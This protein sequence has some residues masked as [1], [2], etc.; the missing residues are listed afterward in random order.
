M[1]AGVEWEEGTGGAEQ[2][3]KRSGSTRTEPEALLVPE[4]GAGAGAEAEPGRKRFG[5]TQTRS[6][7][8]TTGRQMG[9]WPRCSTTP[10]R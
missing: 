2:G 3:R 10:T 5:S 6:S 8:K 7:R 4:A 9:A 1:G